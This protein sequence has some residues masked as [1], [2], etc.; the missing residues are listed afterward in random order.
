MAPSVGA[1][2]WGKGEIGACLEGHC[3]EHG[4]VGDIGTTTPLLCSARASPR[5]RFGF[6]TWGY[7]PLSLLTPIRL[8]ASDVFPSTVP[9]H[10]LSP[11]AGRL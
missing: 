2:G 9:H 10:R 8:T 3:V 6:G 4:I 5:S 7:A 1:L 11:L